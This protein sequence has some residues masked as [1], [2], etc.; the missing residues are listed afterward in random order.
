[1]TD[2]SVTHATFCVE[3]IFDASPR[4]VWDAFAKPDQKARWSC[5][6]TWTMQE[7]TF[8]VGGREVAGG[9][10]AG[11]PFWRFDGTYLDIVDGERF[12]VAYTMNRDDI[13]V[14]ASI[15]TWEIFPDPAGARLKFTDQGAY[16]DGHADPAERE[17]GS[18]LGLDNLAAM[19]RADRDAQ[20]P[21]IQ[22]VA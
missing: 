20:S 11:G 14:S 3:R 4:R 5:H 12:V 21:G 22:A 8:A 7:M 6:E 17:A 18:G 13:P 2:R 19:L 16:L 10:D 15:I 9:S 1:M